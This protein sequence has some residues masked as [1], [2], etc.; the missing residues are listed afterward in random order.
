VLRR[1]KPE[2]H[3]GTTFGVIRRNKARKPRRYNFSGWSGGTKPER[4]GLYNLQGRSGGA[5][6]LQLRRRR[7]PHHKPSEFPAHSAP[8]RAVV[9][10]FT[11]KIKTAFSL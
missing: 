6:P 3:G 1:A 11:D 2:S 7:N 8:E 10:L 9:V 5:L 4:H